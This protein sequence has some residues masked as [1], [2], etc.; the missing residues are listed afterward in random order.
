MIKLARTVPPEYLT[1]EKV[2][3]LTDKF[4]VD[5]S[6][7]WNHKSIKSTLLSMSSYKCCYCE[8]KLQTEDSYMEVE[9]FK[10]KDFYPDDVVN[11][12][13]LLPACKRCNGC[14]GNIDVIKIPIIN[15]TE[16]TPSDHLEVG[17]ARLY[18]VKGSQ[19]GENSIVQLELNCED[20]LVINRF[21]IWDSMLGKLEELQLNLG[22]LS[23]KILNVKLKSILTWC[24][25]DRPYSAVLATL[26][27][28]SVSYVQIR[29]YL[30]DNN[31]WSDQLSELHD[32]TASLKLGMRRTV[33]YPD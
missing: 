9:H 26:L 29:Q 31:I 14:K 6:P 5:S 15:P 22:S 30:M 19:K 20:R 25:K 33:L 10:C 7:V 23:P 24:Q 28:S 8:C 27:H 16:D 2:K 32:E 17:L 11:W 1:S 18:A 12:S 21:K 13:N 4:K 3:T